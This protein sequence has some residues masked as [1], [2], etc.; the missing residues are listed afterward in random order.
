MPSIL[1]GQEKHTSYGLYEK[2]IDT[3]SE[4]EETV[5]VG[6]IKRGNPNSKISEI[7]FLFGTMLVVG[8]LVFF[9]THLLTNGPEKKFEDDNLT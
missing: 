2:A 6:D 5:V 8:G 3:S 7:G 4:E 9:F 1:H